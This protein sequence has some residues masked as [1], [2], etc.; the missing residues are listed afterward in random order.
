MRMT[1]ATLD[2]A[3]Q[4]VGLL[5]GSGP[6][7]LKVPN[8]LSNLSDWARLISNTPN[9]VEIPS[10]GSVPRVALDDV[11]SFYGILPAMAQQHPGSGVVSALTHTPEDFYDM[12]NGMFFPGTGTISLS[13]KFNWDWPKTLFHEYGHALD[14]VGRFKFA[15]KSALERRLDLL[16]RDE[17]SRVFGDDPRYEKE[18]NTVEHI[19]SPMYTDPQDPFFQT[20]QIQG[21]LKDAGKSL[22]E[23]MRETR[24]AEMVA[25]YYAQLQKE[26]L[27]EALS[28]EI[29]ASPWNTTE[30]GYGG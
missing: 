23:F 12:V 25:E 13:K 17:M 18:Y 6:A 5:Q 19:S 21:H 16:Q 26:K 10:Y 7:A 27:Q 15:E 14:D 28:K 1:P 2:N 8:A 24:E 20:P 4:V 29:S 3:R 9:T 30:E 11:K 22:E